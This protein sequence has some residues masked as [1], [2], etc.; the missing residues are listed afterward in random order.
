MMKNFSR[1]PKL[2]QLKVNLELYIKSKANRDYDNL[3]HFQESICFMV[4]L[5]PRVE[6][7]ENQKGW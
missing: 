7:N 5:G 2:Y 3:Q 1:H 6:I 4:S